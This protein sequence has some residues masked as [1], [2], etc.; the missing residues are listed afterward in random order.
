MKITAHEASQGPKEAQRETPTRKSPP[1]EG[2][3]DPPVPTRDPAISP[4]LAKDCGRCRSPHSKATTNYAVGIR[5]AL[6]GDVTV[7]R[8]PDRA[9]IN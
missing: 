2:H 3:A 4:V 8:D 5:S 1:I 9:L 7:Q 6:T